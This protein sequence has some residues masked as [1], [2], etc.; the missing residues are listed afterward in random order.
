M[1]ASIRAIFYILL[2]FRVAKMSIS[3]QAT[4]NKPSSIDWSKCM[5]CQESTGKPLQC[6]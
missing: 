5:L 1:V 3:L 4:E 6:P 2:V